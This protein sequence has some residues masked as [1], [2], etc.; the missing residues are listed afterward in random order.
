MPNGHAGAR[1]RRSRPRLKRTGPS[2]AGTRA[3]RAA[4]PRGGDR[5]PETIL[6][7]F[8]SRRYDAEPPQGGIACRGRAGLPQR[9]S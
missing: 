8:P 7:P 4:P 9:H 1:H 6:T 3:R 5:R 2:A